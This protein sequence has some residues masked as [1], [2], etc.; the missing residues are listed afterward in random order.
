MSRS[1][2]C[3]RAAARWEPI[4]TGVFQALEEAGSTTPGLKVD[5]R[6]QRRTRP[7]AATSARPDRPPARLRHRVEPK[8]P[9]FTPEGDFFRKAAQPDQLTADDDDGPAGLLRQHFN[10]VQLG[11]MKWREQLRHGDGGYAEPAGRLDV[12]NMIAAGGS[13]SVRRTSG[14]GRF[15][16][17]DSEIEAIW[18]ATPTSW[19]PA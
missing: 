11:S 10:Q 2:W 6:R 13:A 12:L 5:R 3:C 17:F 19:R 16:Y 8:I 14:P 15:C 1:H 4:R 9:H 7:R 18:S